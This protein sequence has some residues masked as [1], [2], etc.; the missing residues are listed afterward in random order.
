[1]P[2]GERRFSVYTLEEGEVLL[3]DTVAEYQRLGSQK[4]TDF[5][6][7]KGTGRLKVL[8]FDTFLDYLRCHRLQR[9]Q[10]ISTLTIGVCLLLNF[11]SR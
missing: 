6:P 3:W 8:L 10:F 2:F 1:M 9:M 4:Q 11:F 5:E 7:L